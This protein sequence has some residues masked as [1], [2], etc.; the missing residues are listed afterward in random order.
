MKLFNDSYALFTEFKIKRLSCC[1]S[2]VYSPSTGGD[3]NWWFNSTPVV[4]GVDLN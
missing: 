1:C 3:L 4:T 2:Q